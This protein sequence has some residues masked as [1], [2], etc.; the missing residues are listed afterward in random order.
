[1]K[2][3]AITNLWHRAFRKKPT[4]T[5]DM[6]IKRIAPYFPNIPVREIQDVIIKNAELPQRGLPI[7]D[8]Y[9]IILKRK[10]ILQK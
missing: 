3:K 8:G 1:M 7:I 4:E 10:E 9:D 6:W 5:L 2:E